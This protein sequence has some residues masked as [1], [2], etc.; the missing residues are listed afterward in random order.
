MTVSPDDIIRGVVEFVLPDGSIAQNVY[1]YKMEATADQG[2]TDVRNAIC[3]HLET[4]YSEVVANI[5][6]EVSINPFHAYVIEWDAGEG[7][8]VL[9]RDLGT[10]TFDEQPESLDTSMPNQMAAVVTA[11]T[12]TPKRRGRKFLPGYAENTATEGILETAVVTALTAF[13]SEY[14]DSITTLANVEFVAGVVAEAADAFSAFYAAEVNNV[15][16]TQRRRKPGVG[17]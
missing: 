13:A 4:A 11:L 7:K 15:M 8:W 16:G 10:E 12:K 5:A 6:D 14:I 2:D 3:S 1:T 9:A 17:A